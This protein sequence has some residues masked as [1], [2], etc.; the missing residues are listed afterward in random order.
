MSCC[1]PPPVGS[2]GMG[3]DGTGQEGKG[4]DGT[5][6]SCL[7]GSGL[8]EG[9]GWE[10]MR[11]GSVGFGKDERV[12]AYPCSPIVSFEQQRDTWHCQ[13]DTINLTNNA[14]FLARSGRVYVSVSEE[15]LTRVPLQY[16]HQNHI[17]VKAAAQ[18][19]IPFHSSIFW[20]IRVNKYT[21]QNVDLRKS[22]A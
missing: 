9:I 13:H 2:P 10:M 1:R 16:A 6:R 17:D 8:T 11:S 3:R 18:R 14:Q 4:R 12:F 21:K 22:I 19:F 20:R 7:V 5:G 15:L